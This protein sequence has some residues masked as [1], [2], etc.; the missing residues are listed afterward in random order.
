MAEDGVRRRYCFIVI[1]KATRA[2]RETTPLY[3]THHVILILTDDL[4]RL[5][6]KIGVGVR[7]RKFGEYVGG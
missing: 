5:D 3:P 2:C 7:Q 4:R 1:N 6:V